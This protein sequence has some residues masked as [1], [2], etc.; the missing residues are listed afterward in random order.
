MFEASSQGQEGVLCAVVLELDDSKAWSPISF[1]DMFTTHLSSPRLECSVIKV[2]AGAEFN[3]ELLLSR[4]DAFVLTGSRFNCRDQDSL[5]WFQP[6]TELIRGVESDTTKRLY[7][8][9]FGCQVIAFALGGAVDYNLSGR[10][11]LGAETITLAALAQAIPLFPSDKTTVRA[12]VSHG[13]CVRT[14]PPTNS[15]LLGSSPSC[16]NEIFITGRFG[17][18]L[19]CQSHPE[20]DYEY[21]IAERIWP[22]VVE[23]N[24]RL[25]EKEVDTARASFAS[26]AGRE[27]G[28]DL[29]MK[30]IQAFLCREVSISMAD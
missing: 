3:V 2:A 30:V 8:G 24:K 29:L 25:S 20:F 21:A 17:N 9:C 10:F 11:V 15:R 28:P 22:A 14:L 5:P 16:Q 13:D 26:F 1:G 19:A 7:G 6:L 27:E 4:F 12:I 23:K 18:L